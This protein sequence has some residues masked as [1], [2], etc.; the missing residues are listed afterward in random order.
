MSLA[1][2]PPARFLYI[3]GRAASRVRRYSTQ[4]SFGIVPPVLLGLVLGSQVCLAGELQTRKQ[5]EAEPKLTLSSVQITRGDSVVVRAAGFTPKGAVVGHLV[6]PDRS[7][8]PEMLFTADARGE[9][10]HTI[11]VILTEIGTYELQMIDEESKAVATTRF[12]VVGAPVLANIA[13]QG[14]RTP[15]A[16]KGVWQGTVSRRAEQQVQSATVMMTLTVGETGAV[17]GSI[18]YPALSCG[19]E[20]WFL[21]AS[22]TAAH[23][24]EQITYG[25][26][27]CESHGIII[28]KP[29]RD[30]GLEF[31]RRDPGHPDAAP[32]TGALTRRM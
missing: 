20:L 24:G 6:R 13:S 25:E 4:V 7:E 11:L 14:H 1:G 19:G 27:R 16:Y 23:F 22:G 8:Y 31:E 21:G 18:A 28:V 5:G 32:A 26:E 15:P 12:M 17:V 29:A 9:L 2:S 10:T 3:A 30:G